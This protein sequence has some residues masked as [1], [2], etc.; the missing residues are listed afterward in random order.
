[1][2]SAIENCSAS[3]SPIG[4]PN[5]NTSGNN[6]GDG[7]ALG[8]FINSAAGD[9]NNEAA[10]IGVIIAFGFVAVIGGVRLIRR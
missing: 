9:L 2:G 4:S 5:N 7:S 8:C 3:V 10:L 6:S 1:V